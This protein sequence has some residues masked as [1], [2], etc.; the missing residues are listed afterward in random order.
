MEQRFRNKA[1]VVVGGNSGI[2]LASAK[3]FAR[4]G[5]RVFIVGRDPQT[6]D[7]AARD[8]GRSVSALRV[9]ISELNQIVGL[10]SSLRGSLRRI[11][12]LSIHAG[13][14][15]VS[16][17]ESVSER[18]WDSVLTVNLK[19][20]FFT[21]QQALPLL[22][23]GSSIVLTGSVAGLKGEPGVS[24]YAASKAGVR[25]LGRSLAA[26]LVTRGI[27][28]NV[29]SPGPVETPMLQRVTGIPVE[30]ASGLREQMIAGTPMKRL[31]TPEE[32]AEA[33]LYLA[34]DAAAFIT[35]AELLIDGG[36][37]SV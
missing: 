33:V 24:V 18:D 1:V 7:R 4:E 19:G 17:I 21:I 29:V 13:M 11:D 15:A 9:D 26:E 31:G 36:T 37:C 27:R 3:G 30:A 22:G 10:F 14:G 25:A 5:G 23:S 34:S 6:L 32:I 8:L 35:G 2:G 16:P 20:V 12:V 28:V